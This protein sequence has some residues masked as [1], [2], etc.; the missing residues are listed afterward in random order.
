MVPTRLMQTTSIGKLVAFDCETGSLLLVHPEQFYVH[1]DPFLQ[2]IKEINEIIC[3]Q[4]QDGINWHVPFSREIQQFESYV[5]SIYPSLRVSEVGEGDVWI[6]TADRP[7]SPGI[8]QVLIM[9]DNKIR[10]DFTT[11]K[12]GSGN[13]ILITRCNG[14]N[15]E[16]Y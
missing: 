9:N 2:S 12:F 14:S 11:S 16:R 6:Q 10:Y 1:S 4:N 13:L 7:F 15:C 8:S 5:I 3:S